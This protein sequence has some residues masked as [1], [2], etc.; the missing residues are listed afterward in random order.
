MHREAA[1]YLEYTHTRLPVIEVVRHHLHQTANQTGTHYRHLTGDGISQR[2]R[3][4]V[5]AKIGFPRTIY[6]AVGHH[7]LIIPRRQLVTQAHRRCLL[8]A[9]RQRGR[10]GDRHAAGY[11]GVTVYARHFLNQIFF[12]GDIKTVRGRRYQQGV[13]RRLAGAAQ[14]HQQAA[15]YVVTHGHTEHTRNARVTQ[16][17]R[18]ALRQCRARRDHRAGVSAANIKY[19]SRS[20]FH[21]FARAREINATLKTVG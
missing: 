16:R 4:V 1:S 15:N 9:H 19:Q 11:R 10:R 8:L 7:L 18:H 5:C 6:K 13:Y 3:I 2:K 21:C 17:Y 12:D 20:A 14:P